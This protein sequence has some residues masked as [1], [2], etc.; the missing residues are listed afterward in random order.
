MYRKYVDAIAMQL[1]D[2]GQ[3][4]LSRFSRDVRDE[5]VTS[6]LAQIPLRRL[7]RNFRGSRRN[8]IW[9]E[10]DVTTHGF[11]AD[12][13]QTSRESRHSGIWAFLCMQNAAAADT[14][15]VNLDEFMRL[16]GSIGLKSEPEMEQEFEDALRF[17]DKDGRG[18][19]NA[20]HLKSA[21]QSYGEP[22]ENEDL[23]ELIRMADAKGD[24]KIDY[25]GKLCHAT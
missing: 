22:L 6:P 10:G 14:G 15:S 17:F 1:P 18:L 5:P 20:Q 16:V 9:A 21:L 7:P 19:I 12:L 23:N 13:S 24:G 11:V 3:I 8:G 4:P 25:L 2:L